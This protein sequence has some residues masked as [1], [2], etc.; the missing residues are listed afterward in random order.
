MRYTFNAHIGPEVSLD[1]ATIDYDDQE[2]AIEY[3]HGLLD[4]HPEYTSVEIR[5]EA[6]KPICGIAQGPRNADPL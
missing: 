4:N 5:D 3:A 6:G 2:E 1:L